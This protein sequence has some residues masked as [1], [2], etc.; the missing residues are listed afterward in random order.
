[1][2]RRTSEPLFLWP[3]ADESG[4]GGGGGPDER[5]ED[6]GNN[7]WQPDMPPGEDYV[8]F[9]YTVEEGD[10]PDDTTIDI[11]VPTNLE[12]GDR[13]EIQ[14]VNNS[15]Q[16][17]F[18]FAWAAGYKNGAFPF[19]ITSGQDGGFL[20]EWEATSSTELQHVAGP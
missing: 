15:T 16:T 6:G 5:E 13:V 14:F 20:I 9:R 19:P 1:M 17:G 7:P 11:E 3:D 2:A 12:A 10:H 4:G 8:L 18:I